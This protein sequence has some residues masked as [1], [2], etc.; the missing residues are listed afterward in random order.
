[1]S[2]LG[3]GAA[4]N[5]ALQWLSAAAVDEGTIHVPLWIENA[6]ADWLT[7]LAPDTA[8]ADYT[9]GTQM[10]VTSELNKVRDDSPFANVDAYNPDDDLQGIRVRVDELLTSI[11]DYEPETNIEED[12][13][14][15]KDIAETY[16]YPETRV[17]ALVEGF[18]DR[19]AGRFAR[20]ASRVAAGMQDIQAT[21]TS[22]FGMALAQ[23]EMDRAM[24]V[25]AF[26]AQAQLQRERDT[27]DMTRALIGI[28]HDGRAQRT[29]LLGQGMTAQMDFARLSILAQQDKISQ[30]IEID[31]RDRLWNLELFQYGTNVLAAVGGGMLMPRA[32]TRGERLV[33]SFASAGSFAIQTGLATKSP[34]VGAAAGLVMFGLDALSAPR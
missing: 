6:H 33:S 8:V 30:D 12:A 21:M 23:I 11:D 24:E 9:F 10:N 1:M 4:A 28:L 19:Q 13:A 22:Q 15:A 31:S 3:Q 2:G 14:T 29:Q 26:D 25:N 18:E 27:Q 5:G 34:G 16:I 7:G 20:A 32:Q 17:T